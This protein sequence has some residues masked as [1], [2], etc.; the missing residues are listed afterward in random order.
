[1]GHDVKVVVPKPWHPKL[2]G[3][4]H[5]DCGRPSLLL[6]MRSNSYEFEQVSY[7][8]IP[9]NFLRSDWMFRKKVCY[10]R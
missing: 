7:I 9:R 1:M 4:L 2:A 3:R 10:S 8:S 6:E 5:P